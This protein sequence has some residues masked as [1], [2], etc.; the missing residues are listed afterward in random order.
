MLQL[1]LTTHGVSHHKKVVYQ[2]ANTLLLLV[3]QAGQ[4]VSRSS[5]QEMNTL[6]PTEAASP[7]V[8]SQRRS[9]K[10]DIPSTPQQMPS[11]LPPHFLSTEFPWQ[12]PSDDGK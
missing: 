3:N 2:K 6:F 1:T 11:K 7:T 9:K 4:T 8:A 10:P 12:S 5:G